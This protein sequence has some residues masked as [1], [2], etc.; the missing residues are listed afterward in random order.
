MGLRIIR[1]VGRPATAGCLSFVLSDVVGL[2]Y[3]CTASGAAPIDLS[4]YLTTTY[5]YLEKNSKLEC[6][7]IDF[8]ADLC[9]IE[10]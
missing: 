3:M 5:D 9:I 2:V 10:I 8:S 6:F 7:A 1:T 4:P